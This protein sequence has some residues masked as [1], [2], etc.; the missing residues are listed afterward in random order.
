MSILEEYGTFKDYMSKSND[1]TIRI[2][3]TQGFKTATIQI[4]LWM[5]AYELSTRTVWRQCGHVQFIYTLR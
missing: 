3:A 1:R 2:C 4:V 5:I